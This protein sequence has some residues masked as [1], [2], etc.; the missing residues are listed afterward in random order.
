MSSNP[1]GALLGSLLGGA[2]GQQGGSGGGAGGLLGSLLNALGGGQGGQGGQQ[3]NPLGSLF[4]LVDSKAEPDD[5]VR[6]KAQSWVGS[7]A[8]QDLTPDEVTRL[9]PADAIHQAATEHGISDE[10]AA[11]EIA[12][13]LPQAVDRATPNGAD[14]LQRPLEDVANEVLPGGWGGQ[15]A[16]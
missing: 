1:L 16:A 5:A 2:G 4:G 6:E 15:K 3:S 12:R 10:E 14:D 8:N 9:L 7:G 13:T 11:N